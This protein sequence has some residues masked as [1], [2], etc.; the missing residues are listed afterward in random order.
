MGFI[1]G[2]GLPGLGLPGLISCLGPGLEMFWGPPK[3]SESGVLY[4]PL[5][6]KPTF[7]GRPCGVCK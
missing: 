5:I 3:K 7:L 2:L 1:H 6:P 4:S